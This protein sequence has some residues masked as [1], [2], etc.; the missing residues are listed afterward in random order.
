MKLFEFQP[1]LFSCLKGYNKTTF[2]SDLMA[3]RSDM[4]VVLLYP[5]KQE[6]NLGWNS[7]NFI[8]KSI[9]LYFTT[10]EVTSFFRFVMP[11]TTQSNNSGRNIHKSTPTCFACTS[12]EVMVKYL[13]ITSREVQAKHVGVLLWMFLPLL[14]LCVVDGMTKRKNEVTS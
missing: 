10:Y 11:S 3:I 5:F 6:N 1:K 14:L 7:N 8:R 13:T 12:R 4:K 9:I 2:M